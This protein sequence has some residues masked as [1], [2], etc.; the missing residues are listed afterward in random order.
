MFYYYDSTLNVIQY[1]IIKEILLYIRNLSVH[2]FMIHSTLIKNF[3]SKLIKIL[4][5]TLSLSLFLV[6]NVIIQ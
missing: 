1:I 4:Q 6:N 2:Y 5:D 3:K